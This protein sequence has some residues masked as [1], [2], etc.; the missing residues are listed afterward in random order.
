MLKKPLFGQ[1]SL[2]CGVGRIHV[3][4]VTANRVGGGG[5]RLFAPWAEVNSRHIREHIRS[6]V[7]MPAI[8]GVNE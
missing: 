5:K 1:A 6:D 2:N 8:L 3:F 7:P 4:R